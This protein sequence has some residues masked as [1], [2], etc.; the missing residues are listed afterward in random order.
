VNEDGKNKVDEW[1]AGG[2][3]SV[4][5]SLFSQDVINGWTVQRKTLRVRLET[6]GI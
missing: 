2:D 1:R 5:H 4:G 6:A 3:I